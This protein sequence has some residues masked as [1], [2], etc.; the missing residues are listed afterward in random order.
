MASGCRWHEPPSVHTRGG[1]VVLRDVL[2]RVVSEF[3]WVRQQEAFKT[4]KQRFGASEVWP[5]TCE[6][7]NDWVLLRS[8]K[9][10]REDPY[11]PDCHMIPQ[12]CYASMVDYWV[13]HGRHLESDLR[14][15]HPNMANLSMHVEN[16]EGMSDTPG[17]CVRFNITTDC[18]NSTN[19]ELLREHFADDF[20][21]VQPF[22][23]QSKA[24]KGQA[25]GDPTRY[26]ASGRRWRLGPVA[27]E[28]F[29]CDV[30]AS[31]T[32]TSQAPCDLRPS[33]PGAAAP[34]CVPSMLECARLA[35]QDE[36]CASVITY[37]GTRDGGPGGMYP[38]WCMCLKLSKDVGDAALPRAEDEGR[39]GGVVPEGLDADAPHQVPEAQTAMTCARARSVVR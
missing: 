31:K 7:F 36:D 33:S 37:Y 29:A 15:L 39:V 24:K 28:D 32:L 30:E 8:N 19:M 26:F 25:A 17:P 11:F 20:A 3:C 5:Y 18:I 2:R 16:S 34:T 23:D 10:S 35:S 22:V 14:Q 13:P 38:G 12:W 27:K 9:M 21:Y 4:Y 6:M 1:F